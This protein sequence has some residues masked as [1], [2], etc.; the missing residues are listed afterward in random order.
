MDLRRNAKAFV[1]PYELQDVTLLEDLAMRDYAA[2][3]TGMT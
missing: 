1:W 2:G 3:A